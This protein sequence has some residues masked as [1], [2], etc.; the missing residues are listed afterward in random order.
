MTIQD[1]WNHKLNVDE[2][3]FVKTVLAFFA[4]FS[5]K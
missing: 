1:D 3:N 2:R 4:A 5:F